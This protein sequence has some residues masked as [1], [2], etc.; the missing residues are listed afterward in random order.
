MKIKWNNPESLPEIGTIVLVKFR[1]FKNG[2]DRFETDTVMF[3][4][5]G[6]RILSMTGYEDVIIIGWKLTN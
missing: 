6:E 4:H 5:E 2:C 3:S 1:H